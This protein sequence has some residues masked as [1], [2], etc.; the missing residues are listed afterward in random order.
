MP[1]GRGFNSP[2]EAKRDSLKAI[3]RALQDKN[4]GVRFKEIK[5]ETGF[6]Q[7]TVSARLKDLIKSGSVEYDPINKVYRISSDGLNDL[8]SRELLEVINNSSQMI[9]GSKGGGSVYLDEDLIIKSSVAFS[10]PAIKLTS[11]GYLKRIIHKYF[12][13]YYIHDLARNHLI[14]A[15]FLTGD[16]P[17]GGL[18]ESLREKMVDKKQVLAF[19]LDLGK[20]SEHLSL[21][22]L[23]EVLR[24]A[25]VEDE[26]GVQSPHTRGVGYFGLWRDYAVQER[27]LEFIGDQGRAS[28]GQVCELLGVEELEA[29]SIL[30]EF[31]AKGPSGMEVIDNA[32]NL[33]SSVNIGSE[34]VEVDVSGESLIKLRITKGRPFLVKSVDKEGIYYSRLS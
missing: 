1:P 28:I 26:T 2:A 23:R 24:V 10:Y 11:L 12:M 5:S 13:L 17:L 6:H 33:I 27:V 20:V 9:L 18:V 31:L 34:E 14:D 30:D 3:L 7:S 29:E 25:S 22:Y 21:E 19:K 8:E 32:G 15:R 4:D 16:K